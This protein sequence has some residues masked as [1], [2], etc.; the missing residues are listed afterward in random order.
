MPARVSIIGAGPA[1]FALA[2]DLQNHGKDVLVY[3]HPTHQQHANKVKDRGSLRAR[4]AMEGFVHLELTSDMGEAVAFSNLL[5]LT[6]P[7]TGQETVLHKLKKFSLHLHTIIAIPG[8]LFSLIA[9][10]LDV[11]CIF[12]TNLSPYSC[13]MDKDGLTV[14]GRKNLIYIAPFVQRGRRPHPSAYAAIQDIF[15][16]ELRWCSSILEVCLSNVNGVFHPLMMLLNAGRIESTAGDFLLYRDG[17][18]P[19]V[20]NAML[21][22]DRVR[23]KIGEAL[24]LQLKSAVEVSNECYGQ[25]FA[26]F[27]DLARNS[28]PHNKLRAPSTLDNRNIS[29]DVPDLLVCWCTLAKKLGVD[30]SPIKAV[31]VL[32]EMATGVD[33]ME[34]GRNLRRLNLDTLS[35]AELIARFSPDEPSR[36][37]ANVVAGEMI[38]SR[39]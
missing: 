15:S 38:P 11:G 23:I 22:I 25:G 16:M 13:R 35:Q 17:L 39:L 31:I 36:T 3:S 20:A 4:G 7:S 10:E 2:A 5:V 30:A 8:N 12:E 29:E 9:A 26:D 14:L 18:T 34:T 6:V 33:Y 1:G 27:V 21:A 19:S 37:V 32:V 24:G 28:P